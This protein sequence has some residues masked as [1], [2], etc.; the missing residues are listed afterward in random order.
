MDLV[1]VLSPLSATDP[2]TAPMAGTKA[3]FAVNLHWMAPSGLFLFIFEPFRR[4][5]EPMSRRRM[6]ARMQAERRRTD[7]F[8]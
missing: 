4:E 7:L 2:P 6:S 3:F 5:R 1:A 8:L